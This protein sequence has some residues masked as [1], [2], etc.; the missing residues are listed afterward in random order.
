MKQV[1]SFTTALIIL[2]FSAVTMAQTVPGSAEYMDELSPSFNKL[3]VRTWDYLRV[4]S[5]GHGAFL[6]ESS[7]QNLLRELKDAKEETMLAPGF[8]G[9]DDFKNSLVSYFAVTYSILDEDYDMILDMEAISNESYDAMETYLIAKEK[10]NEKLDEAYYHL[11]KAQTKYADEN[12]LIIHRLEDDEMT[13]KIEKTGRILAYYN[14][15]YLIFFR[16]FKQESMVMEA[17]QRDDLKDF[18]WS[19]KILEFEA[20]VAMEKMN[21]IVAFENDSSLILGA[22]ESLNFYYREATVDAEATRKYYENKK[23]YADGKAEYEKIPQEDLTQA[24]VDKINGI[25]REYNEAI[26]NFHS[27][28]KALNQERVVYLNRWNSIVESFF[29][30][31]SV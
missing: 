8:N 27:L 25:G 11:V 20:K 30:K 4:V 15:V 24:D 28:N 23:R 21:Q 31:H 5:Q 29:K 10:A 12:E 2:L 7:R 14:K 9:S 1:L 13:K 6:V 16:V 22:N 19:N 3:K 17:L 18:E 26:K